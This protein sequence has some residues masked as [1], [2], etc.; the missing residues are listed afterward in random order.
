MLEVSVAMII[1]GILVAVLYPVVLQHIE[2]A[3]TMQVVRDLEHIRG[4]VQQF[5]VRV[6][7]LP[8]YVVHMSEP[9]T[10]NDSSAY[11]FFYSPSQVNRWNGP[12]LDL[13]LDPE[14]RDEETA[15]AWH[16]G[17]DG[18]IYNALY[19]YDPELGFT[20]FHCPRGSYLAVR[21]DG[22]R[23]SEFLRINDIIDGESEPDTINTAFT[24]LQSSMEGK[25]RFH[26]SSGVDINI[27][28]G[29]MYYLITP[30]R[31]PF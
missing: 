13:Q 18:R 12:F 31:A 27:S 24:A 23:T 4:G 21:V 1:V 14:M 2:Y 16:T 5:D 9:I 3:Q 20:L 8:R 17:Y 28:F 29:I 19:C 7:T 6:R 15:D 22:L 25:L 30:S 11:E 10:E 26:E